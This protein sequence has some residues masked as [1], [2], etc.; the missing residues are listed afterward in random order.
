[1]RK[2]V[3]L[4]PEP[5][6]SAS[7]ER[8]RR[9]GLD[10]IA[11][12]LFRIEPIAW[13]PPDPANYD[14]L[15]LTSANAVRHAGTGLRELNRLPAHAVGAATA[16]AAR[17]AGLAIASIGGSGAEQL[18]NDLAPGLTLL[19]LAGEDVREV[20]AN[21]RID[22]L[23]VYRAVV[24]A[25]PRLPPLDNVVVAVHSPRAGAR[26]SE[27]AGPG[28]GT[29]IA[30]ISAAAAEACGPGWA[31]VDVARAPDDASLLALAARLCHTSSPE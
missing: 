22:R 3:L 4:R 30:A 12:P 31:S 9:L 21:Q 19:H 10:A 6:L 26:L 2:L 1:M 25:E 17:D 13:S 29:A 23:T 18:L 20:S 28:R 24:I 5:G 7:A 16:D 11:A 8:A 14:A 15:L 27:L